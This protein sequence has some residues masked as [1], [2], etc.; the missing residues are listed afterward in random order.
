MHNCPYHTVY[1]VHIKNIKIFKDK[2]KK[3]KKKKKGPICRTTSTS[4]GLETYPERIWL[5]VL[6]FFLNISKV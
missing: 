5:R 4:L 3:K 6:L 2:Q 1:I